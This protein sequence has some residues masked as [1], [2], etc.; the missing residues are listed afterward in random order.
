[1]ER[2]GRLYCALGWVFTPDLKKWHVRGANKGFGRSQRA[3]AGGGAIRAARLMLSGEAEG[4]GRDLCVFALDSVTMLAA[5]M[6]TESHGKSDAGVTKSGLRLPLPLHGLRLSNNPHSLPYSTLC[7]PKSVT[8]PGPWF[9]YLHNGDKIQ[10]WP[11][12][13]YKNQGR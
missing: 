12:H 7:D 3:R 13:K 6:E 1:M 11:V 4:C 10:H 2:H 8:E 5:R 9:P